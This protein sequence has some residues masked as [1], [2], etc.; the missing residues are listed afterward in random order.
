MR[1]PVQMVLVRP[2]TAERKLSRFVVAADCRAISSRD[3]ADYLAEARGAQDQPALLIVDAG[4]DP[5]GAIVHI[6]LFKECYP[7]ARVAVLADEYDRNNLVSAYQAG[8][9]ACFVKVMS[10]GGFIRA[11][12]AIM[13]GETILPPELLP[14]IGDPGDH[15]ENPAVHANGALAPDKQSAKALDALPRLSPREKCILRC[16]I[17]GDSNKT[18]ARKIDIAEAT[19]K[20]HVKAI[21]RKA[22]LDNRT[23]AA[24][25]AMNHSSLIWSTDDEAAPVEATA[26]FPSLAPEE[27]RRIDRSPPSQRPGNGTGEVGLLGPDTSL[28]KNRPRS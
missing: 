27:A 21:L 10:C 19:V 17:D 1:R 28:G 13:L 4:D 22:R 7:A 15:H 8:A 26:V 5:E 20:V 12:E 18:I 16:V 3:H 11:L 2:G 6:K 9:N 23:Q 24:I 14:F 25:W